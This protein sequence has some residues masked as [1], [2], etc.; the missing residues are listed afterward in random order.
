MKWT[1]ENDFI[2]PFVQYCANIER[3][4]RSFTYLHPS[5]D[6]FIVKENGSHYV[7]FHS[8]LQM[9]IN[10]SIFNAHWNIRKKDAFC[11]TCIKGYNKRIK[12]NHYALKIRLMPQKASIYQ[13]GFRR[14]W[15][16]AMSF[17]HNANSWTI[18]GEERGYFCVILCFSAEIQSCN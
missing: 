17:T 5:N 2:I 12:N 1:S 3:L 4:K 13:K 14:F 6:S 15:I 10:S 7:S 16:C 8:S 18:P 11:K 9:R